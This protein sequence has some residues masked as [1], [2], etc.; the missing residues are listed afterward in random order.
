MFR[1]WVGE[2]GVLEEG[3]E[4]GGMKWK[5]KICGVK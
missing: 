3:G 2:G 5:C 4:H 1:Y